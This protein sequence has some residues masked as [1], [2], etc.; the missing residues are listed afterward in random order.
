MAQAEAEAEVR[1]AIYRLATRGKSLAAQQAYLELARRRR[2]GPREETRAE[3]QARAEMVRMR[4]VG[5]T[6]QDY[7]GYIALLLD[8]TSPADPEHHRLL[9]RYETALEHCQPA[10]AQAA[11]V[12]VVVV[13]P[14][15][16][17][18]PPPPE[19]PPRND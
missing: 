4:T 8:E 12:Q 16:D 5:Y 1:E 17:I 7:A 14:D 15:E 9:L 10:Q 6:W 2:R 3:M 19:D 13:R 11:T 18:P